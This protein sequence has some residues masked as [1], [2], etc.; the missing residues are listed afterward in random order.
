MVWPNLGSRVSDLATATLD[1][2]FEIGINGDEFPIT[3]GADGN[4][5]TGAGDNRQIGEAYGSFDDMIWDRLSR[6]S[7][8][9]TLP[10]TRRGTGSTWRPC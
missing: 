10:I 5:Y 1:P 8:S 7:F 3:W 2:H 4:Q 9:V 6:V